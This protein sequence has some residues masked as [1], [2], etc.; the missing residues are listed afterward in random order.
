M[1]RR[2]A[3][4]SRGFSLTEV[5]SVVSIFVVLATIAAPTTLTVT[6][7]MRVASAAREFERELQTAR[8]KAVQANRSIRVLFNCPTVGQYR[9]VEVM[10]SLV[11]GQST[12]CSEAAYP[13]P[14]P[15]DTDPSTPLHDGALRYLPTGAA[16]AAGG[17]G[18]EF[19]PDGRTFQVTSTGVQSIRAPG[20][21]LTVTKGLHS[22]TV[23]VNGL[24]RIQIQ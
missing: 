18:L 13:F 2:P 12:R 23:N 14:S 7:A 21:A 5:L 24:G 20:V 9:R 10:N 6:E 19:R 22:S 8:L 15:R 17:L 1:D 11:D 16:L 4:S 3:S